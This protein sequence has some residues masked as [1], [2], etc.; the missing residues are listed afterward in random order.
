MAKCNCNCTFP[1]TLNICP[2]HR[3]LNIYLGWSVSTASEKPLKI[4]FNVSLKYCT[5]RRNLQLSTSWW[6][7]ATCCLSSEEFRSNFSASCCSRIFIYL[8]EIE[9]TK[10]NKFHK[11]IISI[12]S[13]RIS[14]IFLRML[15]NDDLSCV[16]VDESEWEEVSGKMRWELKKILKFQF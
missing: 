9:S 14:N 6:W 3:L 5:W 4:S 12:V 8:P 1:S 10:D 15:L 16:R 11:L 2:W 7:P 13:L